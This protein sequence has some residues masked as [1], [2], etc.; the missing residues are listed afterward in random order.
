MSD[1][2]FLRDVLTDVHPA[3]SAFRAELRD[4]LLEEWRGRA[5][6]TSPTVVPEVAPRHRARWTIGAAAAVMVIVMAG[7]VWLARPDDPSAPPIN[8]SPTLP[9][10]APVS[11]PSTT[12]DVTDTTTL[13]PTQEN[14]FP[15]LT[16]TFVSPRN[17]YSV[18]YVDRGAGTVT[19]ATQLWEPDERVDTGFDVIETGLGAVFKGASA[20][21][22][23][24][25]SDG[26]SIDQR[27]DEYLSVA[28]GAA[29]GCGVPRSEQA[30]V[31]IDG[32]EGR[33]AEC[34]NHI[35]ATVVVGGRLYL[36][37]LTHDRDD[38]RAIFDAFIATVALTPDTAVDF[39][40]MTTTF[41]SPTYGYSFDYL[42]RG[43]LQPATEVWNAADQPPLEIFRG[44]PRMDGVET[45]L[46]AYFEA[47][48][49]AIP[50]VASIDEWV[51]TDVTA[52]SRGGCGV[53][54]SAQ[55][56][57]II[58]GHPGRKAE[59]DNAVGPTGL[60]TST[61]HSEA[62]VVVD[63]RLYVFVGPNDDREWFD[64]WIATIEL[65][66]ETARP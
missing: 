56:E 62:T 53:P 15:P 12:T 60:A 31:A 42:D 32:S 55:E 2:Q 35:E 26:V 4:Q 24:I 49:T 1:D 45:G 61:G 5:A 3:R 65:T 7:L 25:G 54:R 21:V 57:I 37:T 48:S 27:V 13:P 19:P 9:S 52:R 17:G 46:A 40:P 29:D 50:Q 43:G 18:D 38:A 39:P 63:G 66:P 23:T 10:V 6:I 33:V 16:S 36:F 51:D 30:E 58:D 44:D 41:V 28:P 64:G 14:E 22:S 8:T 20:D 34:S 59:C 47:A 11:T